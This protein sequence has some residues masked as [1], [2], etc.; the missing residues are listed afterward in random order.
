[1]GKRAKTAVVIGAGPA[2][3]EAALRIGQAG[4]KAVLVEK[5]AELGGY[6]KKICSSFPRWEDPQEL[7]DRKVGE[8]QGCTNVSIMNSTV[9]V[10]A[11]TKEDG[12]VIT[13]SQT[14]TGRTQRIRVAWRDC[15]SWRRT[16][17]LNIAD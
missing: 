10:D 12:Y 3:M 17:S 13:L 8:L 16:T 14:R 4:F 11:E 2:G 1:M 7:L 9:A 5:E 6:L 15:G